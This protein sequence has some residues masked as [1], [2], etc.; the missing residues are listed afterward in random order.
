MTDAFHH[1]LALY[2]QGRLAEAENALRA[3]QTDAALH[4]LGVIA[5][6]TGR[7]Q[8]AVD[9]IG[10]AIARNPNRAEQYYNRGLALSELGRIE[11]ALTDYEKAIALK[12]AY[13]AAHNNR[14]NALR[15][16]GRPAD[17]LRGYESAIALRPDDADAYNNLGVVLTDLGQLPEALSSFDRAITL[18]PDDAASHANRGNALR[19]QGKFAAAVASYDRAIGLRPDFADALHARG[20]ALAAQ[21]LREVALAS[22]DQ[23]IA[24][25]PDFAEAQRNRSLCHV[26]LSLGQLA[27]GD[28]ECGW[29]AFEWRWQAK[30]ALM[31]RELRGLPWLGD[32]RIEGKTILVHAEG[33]FGD[34]LQFCRYVPMLAARAKVILDVPRPLLRLLS[35]LEGV[36]RII[37]HD[38]PTPPHDAWVPMMS[39]PLAFRTTVATIPAATPYL[40]ADGDIWR[41]RLAAFPGRKIGLVWAGAPRSEQPDQQPWSDSVDRRRSITLHHYAPLA[42]VPG[43]CLISLQ[44]GEAAEQAAAPP[45]G[46]TLHDPSSELRDFADT[47]ALVEALDLVISVDTSAVHL[48]GALGQPVWVLNRYDQ[49]WRWLQDRSDSPWYP[50][51]RL[52]RQRSPGD[53]HG[54]IRT[55]A[56]ALRAGE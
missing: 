53:W 18:R 29:K 37:A 6:R 46:M 30:F 13:P 44:K 22:Y 28:Y 24:L 15:A 16:L 35:G 9:L 36:S 52:F 55:V 39:L 10:A 8:R 20:I 27:A 42:A 31:R 47:A 50:T 34:S 21:G 14:G 32:P 19:A 17:A 51:A 12:P 45:D 33:G 7:S 4:L 48:A 49:C 40:R 41:R 3:E 26:S 11:A 38:E 25:R 43:I 2:R 5:F 56:D 54:V 1:G 23:A